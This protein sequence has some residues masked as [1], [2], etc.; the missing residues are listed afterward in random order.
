MLMLRFNRDWR[1]PSPDKAGFTHPCEELEALIPQA[2]TTE[3][4]DSPRARDLPDDRQAGAVTMS[5]SDIIELATQ[6]WRLEKRLANIDANQHKRIHRQLTD[7]A[8]RFTKILERLGVRFLDPAG[9]PYD[10]GWLEVEVVGWDEAD[11]DAA[12]PPPYVKETIRPII[13][14][15]GELL[16][17]GQVICAE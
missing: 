5:K 3:A 8:R 15:D 12:H 1:I 9:T 7:S 2:L 10:E 6:T 13:H 14:S 16:K 11:P 17:A 4:P